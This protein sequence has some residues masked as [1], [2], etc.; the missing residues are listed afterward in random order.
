[1]PLALPFSERRGRNRR[2]RGSTMDSLG[3]SKLFYCVDTVSSRCRKIVRLDQKYMTR[4]LSDM[5]HKCVIFDSFIFKYS[6]ENPGHFRTWSSHNFITPTG[7][8][9]ARKK[10]SGLEGK[11]SCFYQPCPLPCLPYRY[12]TWL[13]CCR[14]ERLPKLLHTNLQNCR[15]N[16]F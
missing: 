16:A 9:R 12:G 2:C 4:Y 10:E 3:S 15:S 5:T 1:M 7:C 11:S 14:V 8:R 13:Q 6:V